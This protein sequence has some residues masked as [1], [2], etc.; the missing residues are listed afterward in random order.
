MN[1]VIALAIGITAVAGAA[2]VMAL[3]K[4]GKLLTE[5]ELPI[6]EKDYEPDDDAYWESIAEDMNERNCTVESEAKK[7]ETETV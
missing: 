6:P 4:G 3:V 2:I 7:D 5:D 1:K